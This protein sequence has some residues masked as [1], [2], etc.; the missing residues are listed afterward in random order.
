MR[1]N[2]GILFHH[3]LL[4]LVLRELSLLSL[5]SPA[6]SLLSASSEVKIFSSSPK[7]VIISYKL[8]VF[9]NYPILIFFA[10]T[11]LCLCGFKISCAVQRDKD[12]KEEY[13]YLHFQ[14][15][16]FSFSQNIS[17][18]LQFIEYKS[19]KIILFTRVINHILCNLNL[20]FLFSSWFKSTLSSWPL[21]LC[22]FSLILFLKGQCIENLSVH[23]YIFTP[24]SC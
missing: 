1:P 12:K 22:S 17:L 18:F 10:M 21:I 19:I 9:W 2:P 6:A 14:L 5:L 20:K 11:I 4:L 15:L 24:E 3:L 8:D 16:P 13:L 23:V 7:P